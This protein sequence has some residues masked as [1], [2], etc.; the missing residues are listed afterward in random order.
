MRIN[1]KESAVTA[2]EFFLKLLHASTNFHI[3]HLQTT[4]YAQHVA[5]GEFY[6]GIA[7]LTDGLVE[8]YQGTHPIVEYP[9][10]YTAPD[11]TPQIELQDL[12]DY[13]RTNR[14]V[15]GTESNIQNEVDSILNLISTTLYKLNKLK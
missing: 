8:I 5:L 2:G 4:S 12:L 13:V 9:A 10:T 7:E 14:A 1:I 15:I 11:F 6:E 3:H